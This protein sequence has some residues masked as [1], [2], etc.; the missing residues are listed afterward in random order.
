MT[1]SINDT[2][3]TLLCII[4]SVIMLNVAFNY[5]YAECHY[6]ECHNAE[7]HDAECRNGEC[8]GAPFL[9]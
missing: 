6:A 4:L 2:Q 5:C 8:R 9:V 7:C 3:K 1:L